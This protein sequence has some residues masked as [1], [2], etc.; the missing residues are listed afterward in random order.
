M[1]KKALYQ[2]DPD[3]GLKRLQLQLDIGM[4]KQAEFDRLMAEYFPD[5]DKCPCGCEETDEE[6]MANLEREGRI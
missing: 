5:A 6:H 2:T 1:A 3:G 4:I